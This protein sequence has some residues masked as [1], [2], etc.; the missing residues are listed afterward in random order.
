MDVGELLPGRLLM[1]RFPVGQAYL[2]RDG[3]GGR[4]DELTLVDAGPAGSGAPIV[5]AVTALGARPADV[6]RVVLTHFHED[7]AGG[8]AEVAAL[9]GA[10]VLAHRL[11]APHVRDDA[12]GPPPALEDWEL[13]L[14]RR[15]LSLL[16]PGDYERPASVTELSDGDV[17]DVAGG[18]QVLHV[19]GHTRGSIA[20]RLPRYGVLFTGDTVAVSPADGTVI[21]GVFNLDRHR[22]LA[23]CRRLAAL[24]TETACFG[25]GDPVLTDASRRL[26]AMA[27]AAQR[28]TDR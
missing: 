15:A 11:D 9:T 18:A 3:G 12:P 23:S 4:P 20:L 25:H 10:E 6:R 16:P 14:R 22:L 7:H 5:E 2:W 13:P 27:E 17:L 21:P 24:D 8:A 26:R 1:L 28:E 19:P